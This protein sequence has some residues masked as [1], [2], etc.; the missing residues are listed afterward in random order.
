MWNGECFDNACGGW[1]YFVSAA[2]DRLRSAAVR[3]YAAYF[4]GHSRRRVLLP[5]TWV[6]QLKN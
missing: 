2:G 6:L 5:L 4:S 3:P 1:V